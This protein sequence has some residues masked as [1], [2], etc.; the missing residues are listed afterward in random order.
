V[1]VVSRLFTFLRIK[2]TAF[3]DRAEDPRET[4]DYAHEKQQQLLLR[5]RRGL[6]EVATSRNQIEQLRER[7]E[8]GLT[9]TEDQ[10]RR[11]FAAGREDLARLALGRK[12]AAI[13]EIAALDVQFTDL[14]REEGK[15]TLAE[16]QLVARIQEFRT[17]RTTLSARYTAAEAQVRVNEALGGLS[18][19]FAEVGMALGRAEEKIERMQARSVA[20]DALLASGSLSL[21]AGTTDPVERELAAIAAETAIEAELQSMRAQQLPPG[22][23]DRLLASGS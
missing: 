22:D 3:L 9:R 5:V 17:R 4:L 6:V 23:E 19:Q 21:P 2:G 7:Q 13:A 16:Q 18:D 15:L 12:Q 1:S 11:A 10:A 14:A 20:I 8:G